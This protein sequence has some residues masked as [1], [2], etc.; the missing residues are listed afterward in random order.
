MFGQVVVTWR[1][2]VKGE[3]EGYHAEEEWVGESVLEEVIE[4]SGSGWV[5]RG[6]S[7]DFSILP[8]TF[9]NHCIDMGLDH[10]RWQYLSC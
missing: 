7:T 9:S 6:V 4:S 2:R 3:L 5:N 10:H 1:P 8:L